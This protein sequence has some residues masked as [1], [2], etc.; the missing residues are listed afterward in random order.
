VDKNSVVFVIPA[1]NEA[2]VIFSTIQ[3]VVI[4]GHKVICID[5]A[6]N[7]ATGHAASEAGATVIRHLI[8]S[9]QGASLQTGFDFILQ[10]SVN[11]EDAKYVVTFDADGQHSLSDLERFLNAF[12]NR[13]DLDIVLG[14][15]FLSLKFKGSRSKKILLKTMA[16]VSKY[17]FGIKLTDRHNGFRVIRKDKLH[18]FQLKSPGYEHADEFL[19]IISRNH[20]EYLEVATDINYTEYSV[21]KGQP[22]ING[23][24]IVFDRLINGW[25]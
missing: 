19:H 14:S 9:G 25:K 10:R 7:D 17:T 12:K 6:S 3:P 18:Y 16:S 2:D 21:S 20:L 11:F 22:V 23:F 4:A 13:P 15:R 5:D 24:K 8:N 1:F